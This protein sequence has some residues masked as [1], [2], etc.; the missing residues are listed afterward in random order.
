ADEGVSVEGIDGLDGEVETCGVEQDAAADGPVV[1]VALRVATFTEE[2]RG[3]EGSAAQ[4]LRIGD[5]LSDLP[6]RECKL[7]GLVGQRAGA[8]CAERAFGAEAA[9]GFGVEGLLF[10]VDQASLNDARCGNPF[11]R[12]IGGGRQR[13]EGCAY[14][15]DVGE[16][17]AGC[18][19][20]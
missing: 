18:G 13:V 3:V 10:A 4:G 2:Q 19:Q 12:Q 16:A 14:G 9:A 17:C 15:G 5:N 7:I 20:G 1:G 11:E 6:A 8:D